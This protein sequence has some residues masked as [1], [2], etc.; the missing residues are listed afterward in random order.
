MKTC[1][2]IV[3]VYNAD[4]FLTGCLC[5]LSAQTYSALQVIIIDDGSTDQS[6]SIAQ[7]FCDADA[8]F[9]LIKQNNQGQGN[10]RNN[11]MQHATGEFVMFVDADDTISPDYI[12]KHILSIGEHDMT[13]AGYQRVLADGTIIETR[14]PRHRYQFTSPCM[15]L[16]RR[17][18]LCQQAIRFPQDMIYEDVIFSL[19]LWT[20]QPTIVFVQSVGYKYLLNP[21][22]TTSN[23]EPIHRQKLYHAIRQTQAPQWLKLYTLLRLNVHFLKT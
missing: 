11:G 15:R 9:L 2:V 4:S 21:H 17:D 12:E 10:A 8:R 6:A 13:Q 20:A 16:Y 19:R 7:T 14:M 5:S 18:W 23:N 3:P 1:S 22:S